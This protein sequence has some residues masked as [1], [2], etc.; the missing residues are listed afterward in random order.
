V[1]YQNVLVF[2]IE[3]FQDVVVAAGHIRQGTALSPDNITIERRKISDFSFGFF[4]E[5]R[6]VIGK[7]ATRNIRPGAMLTLNQVKEPPVVVPKS[8]IRVVY[9]IP[10]GNK[11]ISVSFEGVAEEEGARGDVIRVRSRATNKQLWCQV[12]DG[13]TAQ[14][15]NAR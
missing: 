8:L 7:L 10:S 14:M 5:P 9:N 3:T 11:S 12:I 13:R 1:A 4:S 15:T 6:K 2:N